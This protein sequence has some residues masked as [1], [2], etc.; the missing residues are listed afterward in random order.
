M[1]GSRLGQQRQKKRGSDGE[2]LRA[3]RGRSRGDQYEISIMQRDECGEK[4]RDGWED[5]NMFK[6][7]ASECDDWCDGGRQEEKFWVRI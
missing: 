6:I 4:E 1:G 7:T 3:D 5:R 2:N